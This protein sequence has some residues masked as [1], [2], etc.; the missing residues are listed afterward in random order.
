MLP[1]QTVGEPQ[2]T[3]APIGD[4][5]GFVAQGLDYKG[6]S[7]RGHLGAA[8]RARDRENFSGALGGVFSPNLALR[9]G[10]QERVGPSGQQPGGEENPWAT[11]PGRPAASP[12]T[13]ATPA[14]ASLTGCRA[15]R[16]DV[17][18]VAATKPRR[19]ST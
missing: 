12:P 1:H 14:L 3:G 15:Q 2:F 9:I 17:A 11:A 19:T 10:E 6:V 4:G 8:L 13:P 7:V 18:R 5:R 16:A